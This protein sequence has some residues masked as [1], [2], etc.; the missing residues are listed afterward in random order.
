[1]LKTVSLILKRPTYLFL[2]LLSST[3][4]Y[5]LL[6]VISNIN[7]FQNTLFRSDFSV[8]VK[9]AV[10]NAAVKNSFDASGV[11]TFII[12][13]LLGLNIAVITFYFRNKISA[14]KAHGS[15]TSFLGALIGIIG[16][17]CAACGSFILTSLLPFFGLGALFT[18]LPFHGKEFGLIGILLL[19]VSLYLT[20]REIQ[21]PKVCSIS[22]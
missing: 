22:E 16:L 14:F 8:Q 21:N 1:M 6:V 12:A 7:L 10:F 2:T 9:A 17:G 15:A 13:I 4:L 11:T 19:F 5:L 20:L 18:F 3:L